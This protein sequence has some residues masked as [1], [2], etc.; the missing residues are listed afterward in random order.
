MQVME[1]PSVA[2]KRSFNH[3]QI[4]THTSNGSLRQSSKNRI[5]LVVKTIEPT[6]AYLVHELKNSWG[7]AGKI[8]SL[9]TSAL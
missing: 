6:N 2:A 9:D 1:G 7:Y 5:D 4:S 3:G 8:R